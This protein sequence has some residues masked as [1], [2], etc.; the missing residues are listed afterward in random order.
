M[1]QVFYQ[2]KAS[3]SPD[4]LIVFQCAFILR[5]HECAPEARFD[6]AAAPGAERAI[7]PQVVEQAP[8]R[9]MPRDAVD[10]Y[11]T[12]LRDTLLMQLRSRPPHSPTPVPVLT[13]FGAAGAKAN[14]LQ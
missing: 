1:H 3:T 11:V 12:F 6:L 7:R 8:C 2:P 13:V 5:L 4:Y 9:D 14:S 10:R